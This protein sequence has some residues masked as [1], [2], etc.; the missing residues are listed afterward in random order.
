MRLVFAAHGWEDYCYWQSTDETVLMRVNRLLGAIVRDPFH[1]IGNPEALRHVLSGC[2]TRRIDG[3]H[4][5]VY[6]VDKEDI[7]VL[8]LRFHYGC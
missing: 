4:R 3:E 1:G 6:L 5:L 2:W 8:Q 7:V